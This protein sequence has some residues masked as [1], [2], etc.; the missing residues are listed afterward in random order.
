M[1]KSFLGA[2]QLHGGHRPTESGRNLVHRLAGS[3]T[4]EDPPWE[5]GAEGRYL[6]CHHHGVVAVHQRGN[7][8]AD[9]H[10]LC[11]LS[12]GT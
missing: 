7:P 9:C 4:D 2:G 10:T 1:L 5:Q 11:G 8:G 12:D 6:L 3:D